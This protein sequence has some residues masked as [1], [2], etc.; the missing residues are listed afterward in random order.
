MPVQLLRRRAARCRRRRGGNWRHDDRFNLVASQ[1]LKV[2]IDGNERER[3]EYHDHGAK[4]GWRNFWIIRHAELSEY[5]S[6]SQTARQLFQAQRRNGVHQA[7]AQIGVNILTTF[8]NILRGEV[9]WMTDDDR[10]PRQPK[11][12]AAAR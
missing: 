8:A 5:H 3:G 11:F 12:P 10:D 2:R 4:H 6:D 9:N 7:L 1:A